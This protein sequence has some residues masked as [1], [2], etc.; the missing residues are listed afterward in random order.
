MRLKLNLNY[1]KQLLFYSSLFF[2]PTQ[3][4]KY[5]FADYALLN[6]VRKDLLAVQVS[7]FMIIVVLFVS[8]YSA[9]LFKLVKRK[10][11]LIFVGFSI[12][13]TLFSVNPVTTV[14]K[15]IIIYLLIF[16]IY[17]VLL[18]KKEKLFNQRLML[19]TIV[20]MLVVQLFLAVFQFWYGRSFGSVFYYLGERSLSITGSDTALV[21]FYNQLRLRPYATFS[22][23]NSM[24]GFFLVL[25][26]FLLYRNK[27][28]EFPNLFLTFVA[29]LISVLLVLLSFSKSAIFI[30]FIV[31]FFYLIKTTDCWFCLLS[32][33]IVLFVVSVIF[34]LTPFLSNSIG[35]RVVY[36]MDSLSII[37]D[38]LWFGT[39]LGS[40][41]KSLSYL[42]PQRP[43]AYLQPV[44]NI[45]LLFLSE[46]GIFGLAVVFLE[47]WLSK[48]AILRF[49][50]KNLV[51]VLI[52][53]FLGFLDHY[54]LNLNQNFFSLV[55]IFL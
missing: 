14:Y 44:H 55:F 29:V 45:F 49:V 7:F 17:A 43:I 50:R 46:T 54:F 38:H 10:Q 9:E 21:Y 47:F 32:R 5:F 4:N 27:T 31:L 35:E 15:W 37:K 8:L 2:L 19:I 53:V 12:V 48:S 22:H 24:A 30:M 33:L 23:P 28:K 3:L 13:N 6:G 52:L 18:F 34:I 1:F 36:F 26:V 41:L 20:S 39:G 25:L 11:F 42:F 16:Y 51:F 40:Y